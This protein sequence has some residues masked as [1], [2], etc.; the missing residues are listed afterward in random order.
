MT[1][2]V[3]S[4]SEFRTNK[5]YV[6]SHG[7][8]WSYTISEYDDGLIRITYQDTPESEVDERLTGLWPEAAIAVAAALVELAHEI[9]PP[10]QAI[11]VESAE[12]R[13]GFYAG[14]AYA[15]WGQEAITAAELADRMIE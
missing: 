13:K 4:M 1:K 14:L 2:R 8:G 10:P 3:D 6:I 7:D 15:E 11:A 12:F 5:R 9:E